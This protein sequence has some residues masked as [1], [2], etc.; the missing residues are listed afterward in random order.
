VKSDVDDTETNFF[1]GVMSQLKCHVC[2]GFGL[3]TECA[4]QC[5]TSLVRFVASADFVC[6]NVMCNNCRLDASNLHVLR[7]YRFFSIVCLAILHLPHIAYC[8]FSVHLVSVYL[9]CYMSFMQKNVW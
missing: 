2:D 9:R 8:C 1:D 7:V 6:V 5:K 3:H 4:T